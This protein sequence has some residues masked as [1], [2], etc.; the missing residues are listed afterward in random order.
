[1]AAHNLADLTGKRFG[2]LTVIKRVL[3]NYQGKQARWLCRCDDGNESIVRTFALK[4]GYIKSCGCLHDELCR[5]R[6][7][8]HGH[9]LSSN[10]SPEFRA[11]INARRRCYD[12]KMISYP[13]YGGRGI[14]MCEEWR[15]D[16][17]AFLRDMGPRPKGTTLD[18]VDNDGNYDKANCRWSDWL[19]QVRNSRHCHYVEYEGRRLTI[20]ELAELA[21]LPYSLVASRIRHGRTPE[22][23][24]STRRRLRNKT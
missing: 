12:T 11:W 8:K 21:K 2:R 20:S 24:V 5:E 13:N 7:T 18:R 4:G 10:R 22:E 14:Q 15:N 19:T 17:T 6:A 23:A 3:P 16:F 9:G 1:M